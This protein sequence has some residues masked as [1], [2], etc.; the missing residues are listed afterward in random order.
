MAKLTYKQRQ[1][2]RKQQFAFPKERRYPINDKAHAR[3]ALSRVS[4]FGT[5]HEK[6]V[7]RSKVYQKYPSLK[8]P[9]RRK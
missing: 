2:L 7:V 1:K 4:R 8:P 9:W 3:N 5:P 6:R